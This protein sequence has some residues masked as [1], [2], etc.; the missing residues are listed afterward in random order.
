MI[1]GSTAAGNVNAWSNPYF[2]ITTNDWGT[3]TVDATCINYPPTTVSVGDPNESVRR[4]L[5]ELKNLFFMKVVV[6]CKHCGQ[7]SAAYTECKHC[8]APVNPNE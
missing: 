1:F 8:G 5:E 3:T 4:E 7:W 6:Q 2:P